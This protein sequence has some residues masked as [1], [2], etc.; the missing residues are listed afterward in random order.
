MKTKTHE[1]LL[2][3]KDIPDAEVDDIV[4]I[5]AQLQDDSRP[6]EPTAT[7]DDIKRVASELDIDDQ[8]VEAAIAKWRSGEQTKSVADR[9][10]RMRKNGIRILVGLLCVTIILGTL[11]ALA[12]GVLTSLGPTAELVATG[13]VIVVA[14]GIL[15]ALFS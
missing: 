7:V 15:R 9:R 10:A 2:R 5:A 3:R 13:A 4:A 6:S 1:A 14:V 8:F 12:F 11:G